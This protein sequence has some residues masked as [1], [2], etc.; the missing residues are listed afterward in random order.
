MDDRVDGVFCKN[1]FHRVKVRKVAVFKGNFFPYN[2]FNS[3]DCLSRGIVKIVEDY[4][5]IP[6]LN[7]LNCLNHTSA[8]DPHTKGVDTVWEPM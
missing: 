8:V 2:S 1:R 6:R 5:I 4:N 7:D 3:T